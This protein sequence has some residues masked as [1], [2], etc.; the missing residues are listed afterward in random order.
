[1]SHFPALGNY[2]CDV[3]VPFRAELL[4]LGKHGRKQGLRREAAMSPQRFDQALFPEFLP[5]LIERLG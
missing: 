4:N 5:C 2:Q 3:V 1:M